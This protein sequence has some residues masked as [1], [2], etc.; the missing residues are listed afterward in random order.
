MIACNLKG[1]LGNLMFQ[2]AA[3]KSLAIDND[4][5]VIF[6]NAKQMIDYLNSIPPAMGYAIEYYNIFKNFNWIAN[7]QFVSNN[8]IHVPFGYHKLDY[9]KGSCYD[10]FFQSEKFFR[11]NRDKILELFQFSEWVTDKS[12]ALFKW[13]GVTCSIHVRRS[14][15]LKLS[16]I[17]TVQDVSYYERAMNFIGDVDK[18]LVFSDDIRWC[19]D[20]FRGDKF[21]FLENN[22]DYIDLAMMSKCR[23]HIIANSSFSWWG[24]W[25]SNN[26][27][28]RVVAPS[29]WFSTNSISSDGII[30][31]NWQKI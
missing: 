11:H 16:H 25:L 8:T 15:Y 23:H 3:L 28:K 18:Y 9:V 1:G 2:I 29:K 24:A 13:P 21:V 10:G 12:D 17:H 30:P 22:K 7:E 26:D 6:P 4:T 14:D 31:D 5:D 19:K 20:N 27:D